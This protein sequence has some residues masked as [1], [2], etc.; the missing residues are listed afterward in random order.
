LL[1]LHEVFIDERFF[2]ASLVQGKFSLFGGNNMAKKKPAT[3]KPK[4][5]AANPADAPAAAASAGQPVATAGKGRKA[6]PDCKEIIAAAARKC[7][8]CGH[9]FI[10]K[11]GKKPA[12]RKGGRPSRNGQQ[13]VGNALGMISSAKALLDEAGGYTAARSI[14]DALAG[15]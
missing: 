14:L 2:L 7:P 15:K 3:R 1:Y 9:E 11:A 13:T 12:K 10:P 4:A 6:C 5:A 8:K